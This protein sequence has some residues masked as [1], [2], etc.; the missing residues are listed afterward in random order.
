MFGLVIMPSNFLGDRFECPV[1]TGTNFVVFLSQPCELH[2]PP[3]RIVIVV[4]LSSG[5]ILLLLLVSLS[6]ILLLLFLLLYQAVFD[7]HLVFPF[8]CVNVNLI[9]GFT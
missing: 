3:R 4:R 7:S 8:S 9:L 5:L 1:T 2:S 6:F